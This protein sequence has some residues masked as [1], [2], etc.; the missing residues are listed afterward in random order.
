[1]KC[2]DAIRDDES[3]TII[4][5]S[6]AAAMTINIRDAIKEQS[7]MNM[8]MTATVLL[9]FIVGSI[10]IATSST[11]MVKNVCFFLKIWFSQPLA[12]FYD[13]TIF[14]CVICVFF[15]LIDTPSKFFVRNCECIKWYS[16]KK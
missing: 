10:T 8:C 5:Q 7:I 13:C 3:T 9:V 1:M 4:S 16:Y 12:I 11:L 15:F 14:V 2:I 6:G